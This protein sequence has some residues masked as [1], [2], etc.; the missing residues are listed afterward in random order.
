LDTV[1][2]N[3]LEAK[4]SPEERFEL[5][6]RYSEWLELRNDSTRYSVLGVDFRADNKK[7]RVVELK[8]AIIEIDGA[9]FFCPS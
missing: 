8:K 9:L 4:N 1:D 7:T 5:L 2:T 3:I 6:A